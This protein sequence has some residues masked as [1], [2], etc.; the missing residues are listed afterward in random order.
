MNASN[1]RSVFAR[2]RKEPTKNEQL[3]Y[4]ALNN[5]NHAIDNLSAIKMQALVGEMMVL[6]DKIEK[7]L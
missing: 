4:A 6:R 1:H 5:I 3:L 7:E 2:R